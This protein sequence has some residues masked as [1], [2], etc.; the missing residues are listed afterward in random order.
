MNPIKIVIAAESEAAAAALRTFVS[1]TK[2]GLEEVAKAAG[3]S[4]GALGQNR[5]AL[6]ELGHVGRATAES[7][8]FGM[9]PLKVM[10]LE[11]PR[12]A[13]AF[14]MM[15]AEMKATL[16][17]LIPGIAGVAAVIGS[18]VLAWKMMRAEH[19][20]VIER[21]NELTQSFK[22]Q[23]EA[24]KNVSMAAKA[25]AITGD[26]SGHLLKMLGLNVGQR[27]FTINP[28]ELTN[29]IGPSVNA[30]APIHGRGNFS[31]SAIGLPDAQDI[32]MVNQ[33]LAKLGVLLRDV[34]PKTHK[35]T[36]VQNPEIQAMVELTHLR[37]RYDVQMS[38]SFEKQRARAHAQHL[39][40][41]RAMDVTLA[42]AENYRK[43]L[44]NNLSSITD[45]RV[46]KAGEDEIAKL[47]PTNIADARAANEEKYQAKLADINAK[48]EAEKLRRQEEFNRK[49]SEIERQWNEEK[50]K[51]V[52]RQEKDLQDAITARREQTTDKSIRLYQDE[53]NARQQMA[54]TQLDAG[55]IDEQ[56]FTDVMVAAARERTAG[57]K[58]YN[59]EL[60]KTA[61]LKQEI[62]RAELEAKLTGIEGNSFL[63]DQEKRDQTLP[64]MKALHAKNESRVSEL[65]DTIGS[66]KDEAAKLEAQK[67]RVEL[68]K[69]QAALE[70]KINAQEHPWADEVAKLKSA[71][72]INMTTLAATFGSV[73]NSAIASIS[74]GI[75]GL[76]E[77]T[78]SWGQALRSIY[79][80]IVNEVVQQIV[81]MAVQWTLQHTL[82]SAISSIFHTGETAKQAAATTAQ[83]G[84]HTAGEAAKTGATAA[85]AGAR[86]GI[87]VMETVWHGLQTG[88]RT[89]IHFAG[90]L[91]MTAATL[92]A[93]LIRHAIAFL[94]MQPYIIL[95]GI[96]AASAVAGIPFV[97]PILAPIAAATTIAGLEALAA[98]DEGGYTGNGGRLEPAGVVHRGEFVM[99]APA[100]QRIGLSNLEAMHNGATSGGGL[101][102]SSG[103]PSAAGNTVS[104][105]THLDHRAMMDAI[106]QDPNH[107]RY[108]QDVMRRNAYRYS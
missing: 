15:N 90:Q 16:V 19:E 27:N 50:T 78:M 94:E 77:G 106:E 18:G 91:A 75:S 6:M 86:G 68:L 40:E 93:S 28:A 30:Q 107:E 82:M 2:G 60:E 24:I 29:S 11:A 103:G 3:H 48:E 66:T 63:T 23:A 92:A 98:F 20:R 36:Y 21:N 58:A 76:I 33:E 56:K 89:A 81:H 59:A 51:T 101:G 102:K 74:H 38:E 83:T 42:T 44:E 17:G 53:Y 55:L 79:N 12:V 25:G 61:K 37:E 96:E 52:A 7:L 57:E 69:Q 34:D 35:V 84:I 97:G 47:S 13:Q 10:A 100:V 70:D 88:I 104:I 65:D 14:T 45:P 49:Q 22:D 105:H 39:E 99:S 62:S 80:S 85:G 72:E 31:M 32:N 4:S 46:R 87:G 1:T 26:E 64:V 8:A 108:I 71:A 43:L 95:A 5:F 41:T 73:F 67:Q 54:I 9:N